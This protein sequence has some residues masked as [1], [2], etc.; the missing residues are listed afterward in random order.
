MPRFGLPIHPPLFAVLALML[1]PAPALAA[2]EPGLAW[3]GA[4]I[5]AGQVVEL[6]WGELPAG[7][8]ETE[9]LLSLD[10]G[11]HFSIR[12]TPELDARERCYRWRVPNL[13]AARARLRMRLGS[14][15]A[16][17]ETAPTPPFRIAGAVARSAPRP[18]FHEGTFWTGLEAPGSAIPDAFAPATRLEAADPGAAAAEAPRLALEP[19]A[20]KSGAMDPVEP[21]PGIATPPVRPAGGPEFFPQRK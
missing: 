17:I 7:V 11:R 16:E 6:A 3:P 4:E 21:L 15:R 8:E 5:T 1:A 2:R 19:P 9:I 14:A 10:D 18:L 13:P 12:V 20:L